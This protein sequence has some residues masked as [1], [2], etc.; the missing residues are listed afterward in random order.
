MG[1]VAF[2]R[3]SPPPMP[4]QPLTQNCTHFKVR[5]FVRRL[6]RFYDGELSHEGLKATQFTLLTH[7]V[8]CGPVGLR[9]LAARVGLDVS[10]LTRNLRPFAEA[11][12][13]DFEPGADQ[14]SRLVVATPGGR[15]KQAAGEVR[16][17]T[18]QLRVAALCGQARLDELHRL[19]DEATAA[20]QA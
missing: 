4:D 12:W 13:I 9:D 17:R 8:R 16:W 2:A 11:G 19:I 18:A 5:R 10:T 15:R 7:I 1:R 14:R 20:L 3:L 6:G